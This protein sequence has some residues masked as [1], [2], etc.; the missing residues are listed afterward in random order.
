[1]QNE[2]SVRDPHARLN[3]Q[4]PQNPVLPIEDAKVGEVSS[5]HYL[6]SSEQDPAYSRSSISSLLSANK[7]QALHFRRHMI[8]RQVRVDAGHLQV[9]VTEQLLERQESASVHQ[10]V[11]G[12]GVTERVPG[13]CRRRNLRSGIQR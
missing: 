1:M 8:R 10:E 11:T 12:E 13:T 2:N 9:A 5:E 7:R 3:P 4:L 6:A